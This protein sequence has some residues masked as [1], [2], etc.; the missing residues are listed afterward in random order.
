MKLY[1]SPTLS[2]VK[3]LGTDVICSSVEDDGFTG[4]QNQ[5]DNDYEWG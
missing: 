2:F 3:L 1:S 4:T 5:N